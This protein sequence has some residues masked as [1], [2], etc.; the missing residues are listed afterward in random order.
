MLYG[1]F[2]P[3]DD[4]ALAQDGLNALLDLTFKERN[5]E[6]LGSFKEDADELRHQ[7]FVHLFPDVSQDEIGA[8]LQR[9]R[10]VILQGP[11]G[12]GKTRMAQN[13]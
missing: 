11:P 6:V 5:V 12:T 8:L 4:R 2:A 1:I 7:Y 3:T 13:Y 9:R 10:Y